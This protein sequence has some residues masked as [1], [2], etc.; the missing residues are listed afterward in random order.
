M[1]E[2]YNLSKKYKFKIIEDA[3]HAA[4]SK[5]FNTKI[6]DCFYSDATIFSFHAAKNFTTGEGGAVLSNNKNLIKKIASL[7][8]HGIMNKNQLNHKRWFY[9]QNFLGLNYRMTDIQAA[10]GITQLNKL[11]K[12]VVQRNKIASI[13]KRKLFKSHLKLQEIPKGY[14][15]SYHLMVILVNSKKINRNK[16]Y[17]Y[18][19]K[20]KIMCNV[21]YIPIYRHNFYRRYKSYIKSF[22]KC[23]KYFKKALTLPLYPSLTQK[24]Q[25]KIIRLINKAI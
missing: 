15:S 14:Y 16:L 3:S 20:N 12:W 5:Y 17:N 10:L 9:K 4:G 18:L 11:S 6:G 8:T 24:N 13:Y 7:R 21:H 22:N 2:I 19:L 23:E 25:I 1:K